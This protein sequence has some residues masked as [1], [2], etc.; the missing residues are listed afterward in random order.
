MGRFI[1]GVLLG[2]GVG[3]LMAPEKGEDTRES[4]S[5]TAGQLKDKF[6][7]LVGRAGAQ[8]DDVKKMLASE[9]SGLSDD[10]RSRINTILEEAGDA[11][12]EKNG[13]YKSEFKPI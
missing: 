7:R 11:E 6:N 5:E 1:T 9:V 13:S 12:G 3:L 4:L 10:V 2:V 8:L